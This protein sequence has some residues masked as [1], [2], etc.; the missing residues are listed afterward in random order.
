MPLLFLSLPVLDLPIIKD[1]NRTNDKKRKTNPKKSPARKTKKKN[2]K[3]DKLASP[4]VV[5]TIATKLN[6]NNQNIPEN[7]FEE[8]EHL[9][10]LPATPAPLVLDYTISEKRV[11]EVDIR[12]YLWK[13]QGEECVIVKPIFIREVNK[14]FLH[15]RA[16]YQGITDE[17]AE[18]LP[19]TMK[20][21]LLSMGKTR[22]ATHEFAVEVTLD[23]TTVLF[24]D[25]F[26][27]W[28]NPRTWGVNI[29]F[30][31]QNFVP[32]M[33]VGGNSEAT[34]SEPEEENEFE[35]YFL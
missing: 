34:E 2:P 26:H 31:P 20:K 23:D 6:S 11:G 21:A 19:T 13:R 5:S 4:A 27:T 35:K 10:N 9:K 29:N 32:E 16:T 12:T 17:D 1:K 3:I 18:E 14:W 22:S 33:V 30:T 24:K 8:Y 7:L 28:M 15:I 25:C